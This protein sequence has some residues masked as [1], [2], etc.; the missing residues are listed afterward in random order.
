MS[1]EQRSKISRACIGKPAVKELKEGTTGHYHY[2]G[3]QEVSA[4][5]A[6]KLADLL[7]FSNDQKDI[8]YKFVKYHDVDLASCRN[9]KFKS[10]VVDIGV[11]HFLDFMKLKLAD[12]YAHQLSKDT[13]YAIDYPDK[14]YERFDKI[15]EENQALSVRD[16]N[17]NGYDLIDL[18]L[19]GKQI[20]ECLDYLVEEV[21]EDA[22]LNNHEKLIELAKS[23]IEKS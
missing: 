17:I 12:A 2:H 9:S 22:T 11:D 13:K 6:E 21:L 8:V 15:L 14:I 16:L 23:F 19:K 10:V 7:K 1:D 18:G 20:G 5:I 4:N 3:H